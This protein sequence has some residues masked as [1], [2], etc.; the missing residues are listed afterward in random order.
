MRE[1]KEQEWKTEWKVEERERGKLCAAAKTATELL[2]R[3]DRQGSTEDVFGY[4]SSRVLVLKE[5]LI[6]SLCRH[7]RL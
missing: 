7:R 5:V 2:G 1:E 4:F 6:V 3:K